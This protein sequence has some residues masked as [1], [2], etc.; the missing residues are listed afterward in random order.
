M[1]IDRRGQRPATEDAGGV[2][3]CH[4]LSKSRS[5]RHGRSARS[6]KE[7]SKEVPFPDDDADAFVDPLAFG[8]VG[9]IGRGGIGSVRVSEI[10]PE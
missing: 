2:L 6:P 1:K 4:V 10:L 3:Q 7:S 9:V 5:A 8:G